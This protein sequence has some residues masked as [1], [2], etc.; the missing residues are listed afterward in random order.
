MTPRHVDQVHYGPP[1]VIFIWRSPE[2]RL[3]FLLLLQLQLH[4]SVLAV[5]FSSL[6]QSEQ[7]QPQFATWGSRPL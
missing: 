2:V 4:S 7:M 5:Y 1:S 3:H 6:D